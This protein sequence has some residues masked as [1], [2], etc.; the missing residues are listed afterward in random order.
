MHRRGLLALLLGGGSAGCLAEY[1]PSGP[2]NPPAGGDPPSQQS[3]G[4]PG[5]SI[6]EWD[7]FEGTD[8]ELVVEVVVGNDADAARSGTLT[9]VVSASGDSYT[10]TESLDVSAGGE[11]V[12]ELHYDVAYEEFAADGGIDLDLS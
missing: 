12:T 8:E 3:S 6:D 5:L 11:S 10:K 4:D 1:A 9:V 7:F 2:R